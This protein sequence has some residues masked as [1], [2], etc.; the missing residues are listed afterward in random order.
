MNKMDAAKKKAT[1]LAYCLEI[2]WERKD[3]DG[4]SDTWDK[5][6]DEEGN[7]KPI[8]S[9]ASGDEEK[10]KEI[11]RKNTHIEE[12]EAE[13][14]KLSNVIKVAH[15]VTDKQKQEIERLKG[16]IEIA[17]VSASVDGYSCGQQSIKLDIVQ[18]WKTFKTENNL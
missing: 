15:E 7:R 6:Y 18:P 10:D 17:F 9:E 13:I 16:L 4:L 12:C 14:C 11:E 1:W 3:L 2:G 8:S 5:Y